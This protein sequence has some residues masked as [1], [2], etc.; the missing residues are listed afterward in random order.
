MD[1]CFSTL[2]AYFDNVEDVTSICEE[3]FTDMSGDD[4]RRM[5]N[6]FDKYCSSGIVFCNIAFQMLKCDADSLKGMIMGVRAIDF[7]YT[8]GH[9]DPHLL[10][11][12]EDAI[13][14]NQDQFLRYINR[15]EA[16]RA[17][18]YTYFGHI[19]EDDEEEDEE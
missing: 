16:D 2:Q 7:Q 18:S 10:S 6:V 11:L 1:A 14:R 15:K 5:A 17:L 4:I 3:P 12:V 8:R 13:V 19:F 9:I